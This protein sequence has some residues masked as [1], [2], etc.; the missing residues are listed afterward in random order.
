MNP[1]G[2]SPDLSDKEDTSDDREAT[3]TFSHGVGKKEKKLHTQGDEYTGVL[4]G[5]SGPA[6]L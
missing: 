4:R 2:F 1:T 6:H 5:P 3:V